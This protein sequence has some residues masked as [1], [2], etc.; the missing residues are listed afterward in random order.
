MNTSFCASR[1]AALDRLHAF[2]PRA[3]DYARTRNVDHPDHDNVSRLSP[4]I[5]CRLISE[6]EVCRAVLQRHSF[7]AGEKFL[8]EVCWRTYWKGW[9]EMHPDIWS[10]WRSDCAALRDQVHPNLDAA[11]SGNTGID[12]F[13]HWVREL[14]DTGYLHNHARMWFASIWI[15]TLNL[16]WQLGADFF[17]RNLLD[18]DPA[19]NTLGWRWVAG[20]QTPGKHYLARAENIQRFTQG[21]FNPKGQLNENAPPRPPEPAAASIPLPKSGPLPPPDGRRRGLLVL[22]EDLSPETV[23]GQTHGLIAAAGGPLCDP[24]ESPNQ[25][26]FRHQAF[27]DAGRRVEQFLQIPFTPLAPQTRLADLGTWILK[28]RLEELVVLAPPVGPWADALNA[29]RLSCPVRRL[30]RRWDSELHPHATAGFFRFK[31][32]C[33]HPKRL[34]ALAG[35][36]GNGLDPVK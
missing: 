9:L 24:N 3:A 34:E 14:L 5:R 22:G 17:Y 11:L 27:E 35:D 8:Q 15:F 18:A 36:P 10:R 31:K 1:A 33:I 32:A 21:R 30:R 19:S 28:E 16:P 13:D 20:V 23:L 12:A 4:S 25:Q 29:L 7:S 26:S 6:A 2:A